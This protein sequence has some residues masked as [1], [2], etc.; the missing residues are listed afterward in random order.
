MEMKFERMNSGIIE[1]NMGGRP[2][3][4]KKRDRRIQRDA[5]QAKYTMWGKKKN[6]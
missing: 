3:E 2:G 5:L 6:S 1:R 4:W